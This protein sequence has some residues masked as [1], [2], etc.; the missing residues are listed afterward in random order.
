MHLM[1]EKSRSRH[2]SSDMSSGVKIDGPYILNISQ[3]HTQS[4]DGT[5]GSISWRQIMRRSCE[6]WPNITIMLTDI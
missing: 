1:S 4:I 5:Y 2:K 6:P 3:R